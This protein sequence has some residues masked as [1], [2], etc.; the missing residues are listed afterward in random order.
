[1]PSTPSPDPAEIIEIRDPEVDVDA[2]MAK[3]RDNVAR[4][5]AEG[6]YS[7][8]LDA[9]ADEVRAASMAE[10]TYTPLVIGEGHDINVTLAGLSAHWI[11][12]E[13][14]FASNMPV[15]GPVIVAVR[16][17]W[18]WMSTKWYVRPILQQIVGFNALVVRALNESAAAQGALTGEL[19]RQQAEIDA[20][21]EEIERLRSDKAA[22]GD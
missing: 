16:R 7:E 19:R 18:N 1:M 9:I 15:F 20:L 2:L 3:V 11:V 6:A 4:R 10:R 5:R 8:D 17:A 21:R 13:V 22:A 14:P 12:R